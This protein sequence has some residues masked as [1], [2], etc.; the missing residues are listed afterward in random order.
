[1]IHK[2]CGQYNNAYTLN[3]ILDPGNKISWLLYAWLDKYNL[4]CKD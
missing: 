2:T 4:G 1:M 3:K